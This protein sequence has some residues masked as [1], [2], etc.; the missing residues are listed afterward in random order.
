MGN[1]SSSVLLSPRSTSGWSLELLFSNEKDNGVRIC[2][3]RNPK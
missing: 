1:F 3:P 2:Y